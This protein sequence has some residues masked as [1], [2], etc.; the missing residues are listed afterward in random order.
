MNGIGD[1]CGCIA[2]FRRIPAMTSTFFD[3]IRLCIK[4]SLIKAELFTGCRLGGFFALQLLL[5]AFLAVASVFS[6]L[7]GE[8]RPEETF[9]W[10]V[11]PDLVSFVSMGYASFASTTSESLVVMMR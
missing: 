5:E 2:A 10:P 6:L 7:P 1:Q 8:D 3:N 11:L 9:P 4:D